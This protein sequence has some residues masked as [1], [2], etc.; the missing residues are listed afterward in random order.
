MSTHGNVPKGYIRFHFA[1]IKYFLTV[2]L[3][4]KVSCSL[5]ILRWSMNEIHRGAIVRWCLSSFTNYC[6]YIFT[7]L[8]YKENCVFWVYVYINQIKNLYLH[9]FTFNSLLCK[10]V[11]SLLSVS[12]NTRSLLRNCTYWKRVYSTWFWYWIWKEYV[13][14]F[15]LIIQW[16]CL[17]TD[18]DMQINCS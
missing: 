3:M 2:Q 17:W 7:W 10:C 9:I 4:A 14:K 12:Q 6:L 1:Y 8:R 16:K 13:L 5:R 15:R 18:T 11:I